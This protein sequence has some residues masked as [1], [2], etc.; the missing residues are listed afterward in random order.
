MRGFNVLLYRNISL[1]TLFSFFT[2]L[3]HEHPQRSDL[4]GR[5]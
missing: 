3:T 2:G 4:T 1:I 5:I